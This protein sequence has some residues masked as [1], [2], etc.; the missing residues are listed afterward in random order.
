MA[1]I[2]TSQFWI[3]GTPI[4]AALTPVIVTLVSEMLNRPTEKLAERFTSEADALP[5]DR[6]LPEAAG[7]GSPPPEEAIDPHPARAAEDAGRRGAPAPRRATGPG[8]RR[9]AAKG[10]DA[11][12]GRR[13]GEGLPPAQ[14]RR[15]ASAARA[16]RGGPS[17]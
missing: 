5:D 16:C 8:R 9:S 14:P 12:P 17:S 7:A 4:A 15:G 2:V 11:R 13:T 1:A 6:M 10:R 3:A